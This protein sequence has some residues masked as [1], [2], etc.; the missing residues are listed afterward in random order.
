M[1]LNNQIRL[2]QARIFQNFQ[3]WSPNGGQSRR[4]LTSTS[5]SPE[6]GIKEK[7]IIPKAIKR[8]DF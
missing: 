5:I 1:N 8:Y 4:L 2:N 6:V 3:R 7:V